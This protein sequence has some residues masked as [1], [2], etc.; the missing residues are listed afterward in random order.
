MNGAG[1]RRILVTGGAGF[2]GANL[3]RELAAADYQIRVYD[4]LSGGSEAYLPPDTDLVVGDILDPERLR[5]SVAGFD[6]IVHLAAHASVPNS[7]E[8]P[9]FDFEQNVVGTFNVLE[10]AR[11]VGV[12]RVVLA[13]SNAVAGAVAV[14]RP[15][16]RLEPTSPYGAA[17]AATE[18]L[19][20]AFAASYGLGVVSLRF[21]NVYGP[22]S[23]HKSSVVAAFIRD[24]LHGQPLT[25]FGDGQQTRDFVYV[26]DLI[27]GIRRILES[28][29]SRMRGQAL[30]IGS[31]VETS[32]EHV[33]DLVSGEIG[34]VDRV[35]LPARTGDVRRSVS[36]ISDT[37]ADFGFTAHWALADGIRETVQWWRKAMTD[38]SLDAVQIASGSD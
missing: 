15:D 30:Q 38:T 22:C 6:A 16:A 31:G 34:G 8:N 10:A 5:A 17:K 3:Y 21:S 23:L 1:A 18:H 4:N 13:S 32:V 11:D 28:P 9:R 35:H 33:A 14:A 12:A 26:G 2:I 24:G 19:G 20:H 36:D 27:N 29:R 7:I 37:T 25:V